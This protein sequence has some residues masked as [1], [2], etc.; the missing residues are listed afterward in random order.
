[1]VSN[2]HTLAL[3]HTGPRGPNPQ[4]AKRLRLAAEETRRLIEDENVV[5]AEALYAK[6]EVLNKERKGQLEEEKAKL[7]AIRQQVG[8][9]PTLSYLL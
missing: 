7:E 6:A 3:T 5:K 9:Q 4:D 8:H 2:P 1:V